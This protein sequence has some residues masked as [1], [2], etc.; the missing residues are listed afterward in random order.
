MG[1]D[2]KSFE[3]AEHFLPDG[4]THQLNYLA[5]EIQDAVENGLD[6]LPCKRCGEYPCRCIPLDERDREV[7]ERER[8]EA[9]E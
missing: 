9:T 6:T 4:A 7:G 2:T 3:L 5:Q 8:W 1:F